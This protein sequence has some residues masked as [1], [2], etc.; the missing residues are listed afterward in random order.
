MLFV[1]CRPQT[2]SFWSHLKLGPP[3]RIFGLL[4]ACKA[5]PRPEKVNLAIG[6][7]VDTDDKPYV[8]K[9]VRKVRRRYRVFGPTKWI[10]VFRMGLGLQ[11][12]SGSSGWVWVFRM[13]L[14]LQDGSGSSEWVWVFRMGLG[15]QNGAGSS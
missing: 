11:N 9:V 1:L 10:W 12:G 13:D 3:D 8:L 6:T 14:G 5:D 7:Y 15:L 4:E 2:A